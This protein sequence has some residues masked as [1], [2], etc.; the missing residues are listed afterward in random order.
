[1]T[2]R[3]VAVTNR[4]NG[5]AAASNNNGPT[6]RMETSRRTRI[7]STPALMSG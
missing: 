1:M 4:Q 5:P 2:F 3:A 7:A 6:I